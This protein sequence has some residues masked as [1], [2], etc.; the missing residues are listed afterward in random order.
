MKRVVMLGFVG[1]MLVLSIVSVSAAMQNNTALK[2]A[3]SFD[4]P[5][6]DGLNDVYSFRNYATAK[7]T[8]PVDGTVEFLTDGVARGLFTDTN[9]IR[10]TGGYVEVK[11]NFAHKWTVVTDIRNFNANQVL[12]SKYV[13]TTGDAIEAA[14]VPCTLNEWGICLRMKMDVGTYGDNNVTGGVAGVVVNPGVDLN[15]G[16]WHQVVITY[17]VGGA[18]VSG[19]AVV[20]WVDKVVRPTEVLLDTVKKIKDADFLLTDDKI[21]QLGAE[22]GAVS[23]ADFDNVFALTDMVTD[24]DVQTDSWMY[25]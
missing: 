4:T 3:L 21:M 6:Y 25:N 12:W 19:S 15:D 16:Q 24:A 20:V 2:S 7:Q 18:L 13:D 8:L 9:A 14:T 23:G 11:E 22:N 10:T 1:M 5:V 17:T